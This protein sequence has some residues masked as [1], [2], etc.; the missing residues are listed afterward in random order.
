MW[1]KQSTA[2]TELVGPILDSAG[3]EY[4]GAVIG[5]LTI[6]KNGTSA[7]MAAA[8]TLTHVANGYYTLVGTTANSDTVGRLTIN[9]NKSTYQMPPHHF[10]V[11]PATVFDALVT[12]AAGGANG[13]LLSDANNRVDLAKWIGVAPLALSS[14]QVQAVVPDTQKV[15]I[16]TIKTQAVTCAAGVAVSPYV[17]ST[18]AA[19]NGTNVNTLASHDPGAT[20]ASSTEVTAIQN[21]TRTVIVVPAVIERP[22]S[23]TDTY[24]IH[25]YLYDEVG[26]MEAPDSAPTVTLVNAAG[27]DR[28]SRLGSTTGTLVGTG[29]YKWTYTNT[30]TDTLEQ[31]LWEFSVVEGGATRLF[32]R[33]TLLVDTTAVD[34]TSSDRTVLNAAATAVALASVATSASAAATSAASVDTKLTSTRAGYLDNLSGGAVA[35]A[36]ALSSVASTLTTAAANVATLLGKFTGITLLAQWLGAMAG[37]QT[38]NSTAQ[39][40]INATGAGSGTYSA[41]TDS[42]EALRDNYT[43]GGDTILVS[44]LLATLRGND[45]VSSGT[46]QAFRYTPLPS[47]PIVVIDSDDNPINLSA[48]AVKM[49]CVN[50]SVPTDT[51]TLTE[52][53]GLTVGGASSNEVSVDY[54]PTFC[55]KYKWWLH[56][57]PSGETDWIVA[58]FGFWDIG[59]APDPR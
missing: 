57:Q 40:E 36:S 8:A 19:V 25:I 32:G 7:A 33:D 59:D 4:T 46:T 5:D 56:Y 58:A 26:N 6:T 35:T 27:T 10:V 50:T 41:T 2:F 38:P 30:S 18:G 49:I 37:K 54:L 22:D 44:P 23:G 28:S 17:G 53:T 47:G 42:Q 45:I 12:N 24:L 48:A 21:N 16:N 15:D 3:V 52:A 13:L 1:L 20:L 11:M 43:T 39:T 31:L 29:H 34:F 14:Q 55:G 9:C 51:W